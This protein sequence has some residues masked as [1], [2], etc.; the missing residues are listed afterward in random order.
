VETISAFGENPEMGESYREIRI[1]EVGEIEDKC[2]S[3][4]EIMK[5]RGR[6]GFVGLV[7]DLV[8]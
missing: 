6:S 2:I 8:R 1:Q 3:K 5:F 7:D 4:F